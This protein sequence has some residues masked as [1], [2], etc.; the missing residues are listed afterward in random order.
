V[1]DKFLSSHG[2]TVFDVEQVSTHGGSL[3]LY[4]CHSEN[5]LITKTS[6]P[7]EIKNEEKNAGF[8]EID[9]YL[10]YSQKVEKTKSNLVNTLDKIKRAGKSVVGYGAHAE[11]HT[12]LNYCGIGTYM[13]DY[14]ADRNPSKQGK[15]LAGVHL[16]IYSPE[17]IPETKPDYVLILPW[18]I[19]VELMNQLSFISSWGG[20][21][22]LP[23][24]ELEVYDAKSNDI[25]NVILK[26][27]IV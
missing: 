11:A 18:S 26:E 7:D 21:F 23:I 3:R 17:K 12:L 6:H 10:L 24:P 16:P 2:L 22:V 14:L 19:K 27:E 8:Q 15:F 4:V 13:L 5:Q 25:T 1:I 9:K 20:R